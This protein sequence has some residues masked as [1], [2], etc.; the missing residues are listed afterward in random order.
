MNYCVDC[1]YYQTPNM[2]CAR[3]QTP[4]MNPVTGTPY[5]RIPVE[6]QYERESEHRPSP[7]DRC[8]MDGKYF[9]SRRELPPLR[10]VGT[11]RFT[12]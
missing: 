6:A 10:Y 12:S 5:I 8:G 11:A 3:P 9:E 4:I 2:Q 1:R 7:N